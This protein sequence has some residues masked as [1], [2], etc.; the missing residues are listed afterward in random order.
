MAP[1]LHTHLPWKVWMDPRLA[2]LPGI[3]PAGPEDWVLRDEAYGPQM[4]ERARLIATVPDRVHALMPQ[5]RPAA[6]EL[7]ALIAARL[8]GLGFARAGGVWTCPDGRRVPDDPAAPLLT[9]GRLVQPDLCLMQPGAEG[10]HVLTGA[11][12]C[13]PSRWTLAEKIGRPL[14]RIHV[15][16]RSYDDQ[17]ARRVQRLF[18]AVRVDQPLMRGNALAHDDPTLFQPRRES[19]PPLP[20]GAGRYIRAERQV[21]IRLPQTGAVVFSIQTCVAPRATLTPEEEAGLTAWHRVFHGPGSIA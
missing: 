4:A 3:V 18:D 1:I 10:E 15:P 7:H 19:D 6:E 12:L 14:T 8:P 13:F 17:M 2:R 5:A 11:I 20:P 9:L 16:V 21:L